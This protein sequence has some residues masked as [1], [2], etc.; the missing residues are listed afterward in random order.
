[1][2]R[3]SGFLKIAIPIILLISIGLIT[4]LPFSSRLGVY[5]DSWYIVM[6]KYLNKDMR[7]LFLSDRPAIGIN[8]SI[9]SKIFLLDFR[10]WFLYALTIRILT[11][12]LFFIIL[13]IIFPKNNVECLFAGILF[14]TYPGFLEQY[15]AGTYQTLLMALLL[16][17]LSVWL[18]LRAFIAKSWK[19]KLPLIVFSVCFQ[20]IYLS[21]VEYL[22]GLE[23]LRLLIIYFH[24]RKQE[25]K[26]FVW[27]QLFIAA[28]P[29]LAG[30]F[31]F[32]FWRF[33]IFQP[34]R[35]RVDETALIGAYLSN[36][37]TYV[38][39][40]LISLGQDLL[41]LFP[42]AYYAPVSSLI[43]LSSRATI[44]KT[45]LI[46]L[47]TVILFI[48]GYL[49]LDKISG[50]ETDPKTN[51]QRNG[52]GNRW[53][54]Y[55]ASIFSL[56]LIMIPINFNQ[57]EI[58]FEYGFD[59]YTLP[60]FIMVVGF[61]VFLL[62]F[63]KAKK[64]LWYLLCSALIMVS[65]MTQIL[66]TNYYG[67]V[68]SVQK[69]FWWQ[70]IWRAPGIR[71]DTVLIPSLPM[72]YGF[73]YDYEIFPLANRIYFP[74]EDTPQIVSALLDSRT[75]YHIANAE[76]SEKEVRTI[77]YSRNYANSLIITLPHKGGCIHVLDSQQLE[78][79]LD[80]DPYIFLVAS[81]SK[82]EN[83][84]MEDQPI[85]IPKEILGDEPVHD[86]C[87]F[88]QKSSL[89][90]QRNDWDAIANLGDEVISSELQAKD[91]TEWAPYLEGYAYNHQSE[92]YQ[93]V[94]SKI[95]QNEF[96][97]KNLCVTYHFMTS[98]DGKE[99]SMYNQIA[100][101]LCRIYSLNPTQ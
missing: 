62:S 91:I 46:S 75:V 39:K 80:V 77:T 61:I 16:F 11:A 38:S 64:F 73:W 13:K 23:G 82:V 43:S 59:R 52:E 27:K 2:K 45:V 33:G 25:D 99:Q 31:L 97:Q 55:L 10:A 84:A 18:M 15:D 93:Y 89:A 24:A 14:L 42:G 12:I 83:I 68:W 34:Q 32:L 56:F 7:S 96:I 3:F 30:A 60:A 90:R 70:L 49:I 6:A 54:V 85:T 48:V 79:P 29:Y 1:M 92:K 57:R 37:K 47:A 19:T 69:D 95:G 65:V 76:L 44:L 87:Y 67:E 98:D 66:N 35:G 50:S 53:V 94:L 20:I 81:R 17:L 63:V 58:Y 22:I 101:D 41:D 51:R 26:P 71:K 88:Y 36:P 40:F 100:Q 78:V 72:N 21:L 9:L 28:I 5:H 4:Y 8:F 74:E 86:W